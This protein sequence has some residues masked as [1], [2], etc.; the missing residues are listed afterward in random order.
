MAVI[1]SGISSD[2][3]TIGAT[4]KAAYTELIDSLGNLGGGK[5]TLKVFYA[6]SF[7]ATATEAMVTL[8]PVTNWVIGATGT[9]FAVTSEKRFVVM[10]MNLFI[11]NA[12][13]ALQW[14]KCTLRVNPLGVVVAG[15]P[16]GVWSMVCSNSAL[17]NYGAGGQSIINPSAF[18]SLFEIIGNGT[19][20]LGI[21]Q[22]GTATAGNYIVL[23]GYEY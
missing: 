8:T 6:D 13:A 20:Q 10:G 9:S 7:T 5:K 14:A 4:S 16:A 1:K 3:L 12:G 17:A 23:W 15:S 21:S 18:P 2:Q 19:L 11:K 22:I